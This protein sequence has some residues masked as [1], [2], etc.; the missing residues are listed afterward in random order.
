AVLGGL[1]GRTTAA[2]TVRDRL[3]GALAA[4]LGPAIIEVE[5]P[6]RRRHRHRLVGV[7]AEEPDAGLAAGADVSAHVELGEIRKPGQRRR[8][9]RPHAG[10]AE[11][12]DRDPGSAVEGLELESGRDQR[13]QQLRRHA[14]VLEE[15]VLPDH[16]H[17]PR[18]ARGGVL[19][20]GA[21]GE[22]AATETVQAPYRAA[23]ALPVAARTAVAAALEPSS[24]EL[25]RATAKTAASSS[26]QTARSSVRRAGLPERPER[27]RGGEPAATRS[28]ASKR[29]WRGNPPTLTAGRTKRNAWTRNGRGR[30]P[31][32]RFTGRPT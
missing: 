13:P 6:P 5:E 20:V 32:R 11:R 3:A 16:P 29:A 27:W 14:P 28:A 22:Q 4:H 12:H 25:R 1:A 19:A 9:A 8:G 24:A 7:E 31:A 17:D 23:A 21:V 18:R 30:S 15:Q 2:R 26:A 10:H